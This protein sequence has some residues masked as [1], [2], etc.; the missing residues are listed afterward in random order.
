MA[1]ASF[2]SLAAFSIMALLATERRDPLDA[3]E[4]CCCLRLMIWSWRNCERWPYSSLPSWLV[5][6]PGS[7]T[8]LLLLTKAD[9]PT[10][11]LFPDELGSMLLRPPQLYWSCCMALSPRSAQLSP[12]RD[13]MSAGNI[14]E[15]LLTVSEAA[16][17]L[18]SAEPCEEKLREP[19]MKLR[20]RLMPRTCTMSTT[21]ILTAA[22][23]FLT[24]SGVQRE[25]AATEL[26]LS[27]TSLSSRI[28]EHQ[29]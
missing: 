14:D 10:F 27:W 24:E 4:P 25:T 11:L 5:E 26:K 18:N 16:T 21:S 7:L 17:D 29:M 1:S 6:T 12:A 3:P 13:L 9:E 22:R 15:K 8:H 19:T 20:L 23:R 28:Y 2:F